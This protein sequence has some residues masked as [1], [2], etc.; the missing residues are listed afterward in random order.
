M[1]NSGVKRGS[2]GAPPGLRKGT[3]D[4]ESHLTRYFYLKNT[5]A[6][7]PKPNATQRADDT[8]TDFGAYGSPLEARAELNMAPAK[9]TR[10]LGTWI[11]GTDSNPHYAES[12][13]WITTPL[14]K[15]TVSGL[16]QVELYLNIN[17]ALSVAVATVGVRLFVWKFDDTKGVNIGAVSHTGPL[18]TNESEYLFSL[19]VQTVALNQQ[20]KLCLEIWAV[21]DDDPGES[22]G[23]V[24]F[25]THYGWQGRDA[26]IICPEPVDVY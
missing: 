3:D 19:G 20:D 8:P 26:R 23:I 21:M 24:T 11:T 1:Q 16:W 12:T 13:S 14:N 22:A 10:S 25:S 17:A 2:L 6:P 7:E 9:S 5:A 4:E 18:D 15:Q